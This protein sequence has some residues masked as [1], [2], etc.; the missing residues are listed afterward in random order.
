MHDDVVAATRSRQV[1]EV[2]G[3]ILDRVELDRLLRIN[4]K[5]LLHIEDLNAMV[6]HL[7]ANEHVVLVSPNLF[8]QSSAFDRDG[9]WSAVV[10]K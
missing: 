4:V 3:H 10:C 1:G 9:N 7:R 8:P 6:D 5:Q 2:S